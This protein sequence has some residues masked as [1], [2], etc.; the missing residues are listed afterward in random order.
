LQTSS[1]HPLSL[2]WLTPDLTQLIKANLLVG[3]AYTWLALLVSLAFPALQNSGTA[4]VWPAAAIATFAALVGGWRWMP[5]I[6]LASWLGNAV[7]MHWP[8]EWALLIT[9]GNVIGP[10]LS[11]SLLRRFIPDI[12]LT[13]ETGHG[14]ALFCILAA[15]NSMISACFGSFAYGMTLPS[16]AVLDTAFLPWF[17]RD[18]TATL[19][20]TPA[21]LLWW[22]DAK[23]PCQLL[24]GNREMW[25]AAATLMLLTTYLFFS[26]SS[27]ITSLVRSAIF[28]IVLP[29]VWVALRFP[30][31]STFTLMA[32]V[33]TLALLGTW[34]GKG[35]LAEMAQPYI[36]LQIIMLTMGMV[37]LFVSAMSIERERAWDALNESYST[38]DQRV[39]ERTQQLTDNLK[40]LEMLLDG[41]PVPMVITRPDQSIVIYANIAAADYAGYSLNKMIGSSSTLYFHRLEDF[42]AIELKLKEEESLSSHEVVL[43]HRDGHTLWA[44]L[45]AVPSRYNDIPVMMFA[46]QDI[47]SAKQRELNLEQLVSTDTLTG[48]ASR[49]H[50]IQRAEEVL[51]QSE[52]NGQSFALLMLD[53]DHFKLVN[54]THGHPAG[55]L[56]L[57]RV[58]ETFRQT[59]RPGDICG[60]LGGEEFA[61]ILS[62]TDTHAALSNAERLRQKINA[63]HITL[64]SGQSVNPSVSIGGVIFTPAMPGDTNAE[65]ML[66]QPVSIE[67]MIEQADQGLYRA[68]KS[69]RNRVVIL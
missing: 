17:V 40:H 5:G 37:T 45:S 3:L 65:N 18:L 54:D 13:L 49:H 42:Q 39:N 32:L 24:R 14:I 55:D 36:R 21:L 67:S 9:L 34:T 69:G 56:V 30:Q 11:I 63:L 23:T 20:L 15:F 4:P 57:C 52:R 35:V 61:V 6:A 19:I 31:R 33:L 10:M 58:S 1:S 38:L 44:L 22:R 64:A 25:L 41:L 2:T 7:F 26:P 47:S 46:F 66:P 59:L 68:K 50:F 12:T 28:L 51:R 43:R 48:V 29:L 60:R 27:D 8:S 62:N 53:L 16:D